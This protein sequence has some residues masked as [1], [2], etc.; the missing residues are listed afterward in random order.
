MCT[1]S[2]IPSD[3]GYELFCN[4]DEQKTRA[5]AL[6]PEVIESGTVRFIAPIDTGGGGTWIAVNQ[7][8]LALCLLNGV[9]ASCNSSLKSRGHVVVSLATAACVAEAYDRVSRTSLVD[10]APFRLLFLQPGRPVV[11]LAWDRHALSNDE[12]AGRLL[13]SSSVDDS[14]VRQAR[15]REFRRVA[16][17]PEQHLAFHGSHG[18]A[19]SAYSPCMHRADAETV[20]FTRIKVSDSEVIV[21]YSPA[22]PCG[23]YPS[24][25]SRLAIA[26]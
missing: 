4:R 10:F 17:T 24:V 22:P 16:M 20:S 2:W 23:R 13:S 25:V 5:A 3:D 21:N 11:V 18:E 6:A 26:P 9:G 14:G 7:F 12:Q 15:E 1:V 19:A 8:G